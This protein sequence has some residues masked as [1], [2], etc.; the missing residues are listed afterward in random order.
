[1]GPAFQAKFT[2]SDT[3]V[4]A[5]STAIRATSR[6][7]EAIDLFVMANTSGGGGLP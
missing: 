4:A 3:P 2:V 6:E 5:N 1:M 7:R